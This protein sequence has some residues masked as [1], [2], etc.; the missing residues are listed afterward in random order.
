MPA[1]EVGW[2]PT[3]FDDAAR[4][5]CA[6][7]G[8][9]ARARRPRMAQ[10]RMH[11]PAGPALLA[12]SA[13]VRAGLPRR[14]RRP[15]ACSSTSRPRARC[16]RN[17]REAAAD[18]LAE[19]RPAGR[20]RDRQRR[21]AGRPASA[22]RSASPIASA[23]SARGRHPR[24]EIPRAIIGLRGDRAHDVPARLLRR[25]RRARGDRGRPDQA[26]AR[27]S[28][29]HVSRGKLCRKCS[30]GY[31]GALLDP[32]LRLTTPLRRMRAEGRRALRADRLARGDRGGRRP[33][34]AIADG[35]GAARMLN[36]HYTGTCALIDRHFPQ[37]FFNRLGATEV[38]PDTVCNNAGHV[39]L[40]YVYGS[41]E[42]GFDPEAAAEAAC[43]VVWG[44][45][46]SASAP[47]QHDHWLREA[48][49]AGHRDRPDPH[50]V[51]GRRPTPTSS[52]RPGSDAAL[53]FALA[54]VIRRDGLVDR[55]LRARMRARLRRARAAD[56]RAARRPGR[57]SRP[58]CRRA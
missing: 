19:R 55:R 22:S 9:S 3:D 48:T 52:L 41:S 47:H 32:S 10:L 25:L 38:E 17:G 46:P 28:G 16:S 2:V 30:I 21:A 18:E 50:A 49:G 53:A 31:N 4:E 23:R 43:I 33:A 42:D 40:T 27:R 8:R 37:R 56:R 58:A 54:H 5:R 51:G 13:A 15:G 36:A 29:H 39:A 7:G 1:G 35:R 20:G 24:L 34:D 44:A 14:R 57:R 45:N 11:P 6:A 12:R 26:R